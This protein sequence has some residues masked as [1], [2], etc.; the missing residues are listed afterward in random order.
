MEQKKNQNPKLRKRKTRAEREE[1]LRNRMGLHFLNHKE[2]L[3]LKKAFQSLDKDK[4]NSLS[5]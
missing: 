4:S 5:K 2:L 3:Y 1:I